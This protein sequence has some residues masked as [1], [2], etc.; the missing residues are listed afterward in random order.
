MQLLLRWT[1][2]AMIIAI[3]AWLLPGVDVNSFWTAMIVAA[4][5]ALLN[6]FVKP[7]LIILTIPVTV[8]TLGLFILIINAII[9]LMASALVQGFHVES[10]WWALIFSLLNSLL[11]TMINNAE[12]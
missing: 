9:I 5:L 6:V 2:S 4:V 7:F 3:I 1:A 8:F 12:F 10:F 11:N